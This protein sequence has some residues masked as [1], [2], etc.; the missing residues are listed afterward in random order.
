MQSEP[1]L[2]SHAELADWGY[3]SRRRRELI[4]NGMLVPLRR[5][6]FAVGD[7]WERA[8]PEMRIV[9][10]ARA[11]AAASEEPPVFSHETAGAV[12]GAALYR[13]SATRVHAIVSEGRPGAAGGV[14]RHRG[15]LPDG[16]VVV[17]DDIRCT[18]LERTVADMAR[19][20]T[21]ESAVTVGDAA[22]RM[23]CTPEPHEYDHDTAEEFRA[24]ALEIARRSAHGVSA[25]QRVLR[26]ADGR[27]QLPGE[28]ISRIRLAELGFRRPQLQVAVP[29]A[30]NGR[31]YYVDF[32]LG[33]VRALGEFDGRIKYEDGRLLVDRTPDEVFDDEKQREDWI[34]GVTGLPLVRWGWT[35]IRTAAK[36]GARLAAFGIHPPG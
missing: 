4:A 20:A 29:S 10:R 2:L 19:T 5:G 35:D 9:A 25:A 24:T 33:D 34:R 11:L 30:R 36:L 28:S 13:A 21:F 22:L 18:S 14:V 17:V 6:L 3:S 23:R 1:R 16:D 12:H 32:G 27:A 26:F 8:S 15:E 31:M 7:E